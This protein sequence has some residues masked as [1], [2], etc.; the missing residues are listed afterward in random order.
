MLSY[1]SDADFITLTLLS[2]SPVSQTWYPSLYYNHGFKQ[3]YLKSFP[4]LLTKP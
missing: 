4:S 1:A 3:I 2:T